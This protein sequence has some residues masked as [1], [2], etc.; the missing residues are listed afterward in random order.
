MAERMIINLRLYAPCLYASRRPA[1]HLREL[2][3]SPVLFYLIC[4]P[5][6]QG[7]FVI[8]WSRLDEHHT[9]SRFVNLELPKPVLTGAERVFGRG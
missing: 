8:T 5:V 7:A 9:P 6:V 2:A 3:S 1:R 4:G